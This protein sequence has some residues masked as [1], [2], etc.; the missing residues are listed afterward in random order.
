MQLDTE[1]V[2]PSQ[3]A[4]FL[5]GRLVAIDC[6]SEPQAILEI[7]SANKTYHLRAKDRTK[8]PVI[9]ADQFSCEWKG[10][11]VAVNYWEVGEAAGTLI[12][13]EIQ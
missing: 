4:S 13:L 5:K 10:M 9:G 6:N 1:K 11:A 2:L 7:E 3:P 12:S 8:L